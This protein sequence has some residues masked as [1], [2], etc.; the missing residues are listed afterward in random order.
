MTLSFT[1]APSANAGSDSDYCENNAA[2]PLAGDVDLAT[3]GQWTG[4]N[5]SFN[6]DATTLTTLYTPSAAEVAAG[7]VTLTLV[8]TGNGGC[9]SESDPV[10]FTF[11]SAPTIEAGI[12]QTLCANNAEADLEGSQMGAGGVL[13]T[14]GLGTFSPNAND[15][16][17]TYIP[18]QSELDAGTVILNIETTANGTCLKVEDQVTMNFTPAPTIAAGTNQS[19]CENNAEATLNGTVSIASGAE[20]S[21]GMGTFVPNN[22]TLNAVY[23]PTQ[24]EIDAGSVNICLLYTSPSPRDRQKTR[25]PSSA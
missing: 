11:T 21:G 2:I 3:G 13:W 4:G 12:S 23:N 9:A 17:A 7:S 6:P 20:W 22:T 16:E 25:M 14:G 8:T 19:L 5:G 10:V 24:A 1:T 15:P 18:T